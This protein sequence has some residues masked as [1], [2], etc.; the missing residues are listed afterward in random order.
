[1]SKTSGSIFGTYSVLYLL[2]RCNLL[3]EFGL[4]QI[5][6][7]HLGECYANVCAFAGRQETIPYAHNLLTI[8]LR[9]CHPTIQHLGQRHQLDK[10]VTALGC[11]LTS[12]LE[13]SVRFG[14]KLTQRQLPPSSNHMRLAETARQLVGLQM[15]TL[16][17]QPNSFLLIRID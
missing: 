16:F 14:H 10:E 11:T 3:M 7:K 8:H 1:M 6:Q 9:I 12:S 4:K 15:H 5:T 2:A 17:V 13:P